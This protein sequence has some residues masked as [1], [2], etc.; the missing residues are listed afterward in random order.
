[1]RCRAPTKSALCIR[2]V[3]PTQSL[4]SKRL[5]N[6]SRVPTTALTHS[7]KQLPVGALNEDCMQVRDYLHV[8]AAPGN[9]I[10]WQPPAVILLFPLLGSLDDAVA[11]DMAALGCLPLLLQDACGARHV[12]PVGGGTSSA[13]QAAAP[14]VSVA[15]C[16]ECRTSATPQAAAPRVAEADAID[17]RVAAALTTQAVPEAAAPAVAPGHMAATTGLSN[18]SGPLAHDIGC[19]AAAALAA[20]VPKPPAPTQANLDTTTLCALVSCASSLEQEV[21]LDSLR[22]WVTGNK[23]WA[24]CLD[25][26]RAARDTS[27]LC[28]IVREPQ[29]LVPDQIPSL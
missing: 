5:G 24:L 10:A 27:V 11:A 4:D 16:K 26:V 13:P 29:L 19:N 12:V 2:G 25:E 9:S 15:G 22:Q 28:E 7:E 14:I 6:C 1:M 3:V 18:R 17:G 8:A 23:H 20:L 21:P